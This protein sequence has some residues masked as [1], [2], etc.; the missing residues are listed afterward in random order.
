MFSGKVLGN[1]TELYLF[2]KVKSLAVT[3]FAHTIIGILI[4][5]PHI[6]SLDSSSLNFS[7]AL[8]VDLP[9]TITSIPNY[10]A[11]VKN[12]IIRAVT[13]PSISNNSYLGGEI[14]VPDESV[15][16]YKTA[17]G[18]TRFA[19]KIHPISEYDV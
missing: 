3:A 8:L 18:W 6:S 16:S 4:I 10:T 7:S 12:S 15:E 9:D 5:P 14:Y 13:P 11:N 1:F 2:V 17:T 19:A